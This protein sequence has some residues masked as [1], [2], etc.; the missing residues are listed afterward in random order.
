MPLPSG[1][2]VGGKSP[3]ASRPKNLA[4]C[5]KASPLGPPTSRKATTPRRVVPFLCRGCDFLAVILVGRDQQLDPP[6]LA[7]MH[8]WTSR[9]TRQSFKRDEQGKLLLQLA[10][11]LWTRGAACL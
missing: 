2:R 11:R 5:A 10:A 8:W 1:M 9:G 3:K 6:E 4:R 7:A